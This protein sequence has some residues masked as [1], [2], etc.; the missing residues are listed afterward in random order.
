MA[1]EAGGR[2]HRAS[3]KYG[4]VDWLFREYK[5]SEAYL[6]RAANAP[7][8]RTDIKL[9]TDI[10]TNKE[11]PV[12]DLKTNATTPISADKLYNLQGP[13]GS[14]LR[15]G[16]KAIVLYRRACELFIDS[17]PTFLIQRC[18]IRGRA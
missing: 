12:G 9:L 1:C 2:A 16:K 10:V 4:T 8:L 18:R 5:Q 11:D 15:Q 3:C 7:R 13:R 6:E 17:I 14:R